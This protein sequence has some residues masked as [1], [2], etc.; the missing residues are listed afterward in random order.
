[1]T[2]MNAFIVHWT[3]LFLL[4]QCRVTGAAYR[5][6]SQIHRVFICLA[7]SWK[8]SKLRSRSTLTTELSKWGKFWRTGK[9]IRRK[10]ALSLLALWE[11]KG[12]LKSK[13]MLIILILLKFRYEFF[14]DGYFIEDQNKNID[15][16]I[17][18]IEFKQLFTDFIRERYIS[19]IFFKD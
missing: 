5:C 12:S 7:K 18:L 16:F 19:S 3:I 13:L 14:A 6:S 9:N 17:L 2:I 8:E 11:K 1:M 4:N 15:L 10:T